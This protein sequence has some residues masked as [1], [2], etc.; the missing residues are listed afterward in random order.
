[1]A[2]LVTGGTG[3]IGSHT[4]LELVRA[5]YDVV[6]LDNLSNS[7]RTA[8][9]RVERL[10]GKPVPFHHADIRD[11]KAM[12]G[13]FAA[14]GIDAVIHFAG[15]KSVGD[16]VDHP[17]RYFD[18]NVTGTVVLLEVMRDHG[19]KTLVFSSSATV[20]GDPASVPVTEES[21]LS[22]V[23]PYG[24]SKLFIEDMLRDLYRAEPD[25]RIS[26]LRYFNPT[27]ADPSGDIGEDPN[28]IPTNLMPYV[29]QVAVGKLPEVHVYGGDYATRDGTGVRDY[30][31]VTDLAAGHLRALEKL[32]T[33][34][35]IITCNLGT[36]RGYTVLEAIH[37]FERA[38][39]RPIPYRI[40]DR[41]PGDAAE[42]WADVG[43]AK[44]DLGWE[45]S[46]GLDEMCADVWRWQSQNPGGYA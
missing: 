33:G 21:P 27:G 18:N 45:A 17:L 38:A 34:P 7:H 35:G 43:R 20:Y 23:N 13:V 5:G 37:A 12:E 30:I 8:L 26:L 1:M 10:G 46:R 29:A 31:H 24:R 16:S 44:R 9:E 28:G 42:C 22:A 41:R 25:W 3:Y 19:V 11:R 36:G 32:S 14:G 40:A 15:L 39:G 4:C 2:I 6:A